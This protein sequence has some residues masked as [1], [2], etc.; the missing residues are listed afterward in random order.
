[1]KQISKS[2]LKEEFLALSE[3]EKIEWAKNNP[4]PKPKPRPTNNIHKMLKRKATKRI[5]DNQGHLKKYREN[6]EAIWHEAY[7]QKRMLLYRHNKE[8]RDNWNY[9]RALKRY[10]A[11]L[12]HDHVWN[13]KY[14][15]KYKGNLDKFTEDFELDNGYFAEGLTTK[16]LGSLMPISHVI[17][18]RFIEAEILPAPLYKGRLLAKKKIE[19]KLTEFYTVAESEAILKVWAQYWKK[20]RLVREQFQADWLKKKFLIEF[21]KVRNNDKK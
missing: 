20:Y 1:M 2:L 18:N 12:Y 14:R 19:D 5:I 11:N 7:N 3:E 15:N 13:Q 8:Y 10:Q 17:L 21:M 9:L 4:P 6:K 16:K